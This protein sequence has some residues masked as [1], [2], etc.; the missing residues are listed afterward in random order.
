MP[1]QDAG[2]HEPDPRIAAYKALVAI[3]CEACQHWGKGEMPERLRLWWEEHQADDVI[4]VQQME[5]QRARSIA[6]LEQQQRQI[7]AE[8]QRLKAT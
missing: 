5:R 4:R 1:C 6:R 2:P 3:M 7:A 8:L